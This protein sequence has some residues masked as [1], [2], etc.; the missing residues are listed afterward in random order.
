MNEQ[1]VI[2]NIKEIYRKRRAALYAL[3]LEYAAKALRSFYLKQR[4]GAFWKNRTNTALNT[5]FTRAFIEGDVIGWFMAHAVEYGPYLEL[6]NDGLHEAIR[7]T[8]MIYFP[9]FIRAAKK[10]FSD[11]A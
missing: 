10:L 11:A 1:K 4:G 8:V 7:P 6:A 9:Q 5:M 3:S 2:A